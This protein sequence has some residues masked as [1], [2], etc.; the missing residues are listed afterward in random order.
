MQK[1]R[2]RSGLAVVHERAL[3]RFL[4]DRNNASFN[5]NRFVC[6]DAKIVRSPAV[7]GFT[8]GHTWPQR[9][10]RKWFCESRLNAQKK[11]IQA[12]DVRNAPRIPPITLKIGG[13][14]FEKHKTAINRNPQDFTAHSAY[15]KLEI[16]VLE[17]GASIFKALSAETCPSR[18]SSSLTKSSCHDTTPIGDANAST[19]DILSHE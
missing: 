2:S 14:K 15:L 8:S 19:H 9:T 13:R 10:A 5:I 6:F 18:S 4:L 1:G 11:E 3:R 17:E 16:H 7:N 12:A